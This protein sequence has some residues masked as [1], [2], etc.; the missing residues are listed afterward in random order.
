MNKELQQKVKD[1]LKII[2]VSIATSF[3]YM[4]LSLAEFTFTYPFHDHTHHPFMYTEIIAFA[5]L[6]CYLPITLLL[7]WIV[8]KL[9]AKI[10]IRKFI[11]YFIMFG[12]IF[13]FVYWHISKIIYD[14]KVQ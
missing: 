1:E 3:L 8:P 14:L 7:F 13:A 6:T 2:L 10:K 9:R 11:F 12:W 5:F 4:I